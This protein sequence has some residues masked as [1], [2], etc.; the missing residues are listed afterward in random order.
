MEF[1]LTLSAVMLLLAG[2][3]FTCRFR[4]FFILHPIKTLRLLPSGGAKQMLLSLGGTVGVGNI[5][6]VSVA[7][8][9]GGS[10][11]VFWMWIG[12]LVAMALKY[13]EITLGMLHRGGAPKYIKSALGS[14]AAGLFAALLIVDAVVMGAMIQASAVSEAMHKAVGLSPVVSGIFLC[15]LAAAVFF[16]SIDLFKLS[17]VVVP[18]MS[19]GYVLC[20][21]VVIAVNS[22]NLIP[23][24]KNI[25]ANALDTKAAT[26]GVLGFLFTPA[27][28]QGI[29]KG[30]FSNEA[31]CGTAPMAHA[32]SKE[33]VPAKQGL[34]GAVEVFVDTILMCTLTALAILMTGCENI[35]GVSACIE[36]FATVFG[37]AAPPMLAVAV[38]LFA[39]AA[40]V[41]FG[42]YGTQS[43]EYFSA[44]EKGKNAFLLAYCVSVFVGATLSP[45][46]AWSI[47]DVVICIMLLVNTT[48]VFLS[49]KQILSAHA[50]LTPTS[51]SVRIKRQ[52]R[53]FSRSHR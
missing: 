42:Y 26:G 13:A 41:S 52:E 19:V 33:K 9:L 4:A 34:Y 1:L 2:G 30:L 35:G 6:G 18:I 39:F 27:M 49:R 36:A 8:A 32:A 5:A 53:S 37:A 22:E 20:T 31:G 25:V 24:L 48:A 15:L 51:E 11:A 47:S 29:V 12:A 43:L 10:G 7:I 28:R 16:F 44:G 21:L 40:I 45:A 17:S 14:L 50:E 23:T 3:Y 38:L 46:L